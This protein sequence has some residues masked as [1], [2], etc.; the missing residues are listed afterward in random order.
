M[1]AKTQKT[2]DDILSKRR[3]FPFGYLMKYVNGTERKEVDKSFLDLLSSHSKQEWAYIYKECAKSCNYFYADLRAISYID[4]DWYKK[5]Y[6]SEEIKDGRYPYIPFDPA[7]FYKLMTKLKNKYNLNSFLDI[8]AGYGDKVLIASDIFNVAH[9]I[10]YINEY[11][12]IASSFGINLINV[13]AFEFKDYQ[14][15]D[16]L[17]MYHPIHDEGFYVELVTHVLKKMRIGG[18][19]VEVYDPHKEFISTV[20]KLKD[21][22]NLKVT[23]KSFDCTLVYK[24]TR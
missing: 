16:L 12:D 20:N 24:K 8:G 22:L 17:Y 23:R 5:C 3:N 14:L 7:K 15:Y 9:G 1:N 2:I 4:A 19:L 18:Y 21:E 13:D 10:E 6:R 11:V